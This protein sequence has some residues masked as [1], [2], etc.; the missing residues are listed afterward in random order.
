MLPAALIRPMVADVGMDAQ[1][2]RGIFLP[3]T[4]FRPADLPTVMRKAY[5]LASLDTAPR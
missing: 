2:L 4:D 1:P 3:R 5:D